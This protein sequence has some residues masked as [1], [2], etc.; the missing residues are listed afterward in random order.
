M[1]VQFGVVDGVGGLRD[2]LARLVLVERPGREGEPH[3]LHTAPGLLRLVLL[4]DGALGR[5]RR[6][7]GV[8]QAVVLPEAHAGLVFLVL[9]QKVH[10]FLG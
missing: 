3:Q 10:V 7:G 2:D 6:D 4:L 8:D 1:G 5:G 9:R